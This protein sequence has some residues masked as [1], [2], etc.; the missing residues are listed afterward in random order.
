MLWLSM[1]VSGFPSGSAIPSC[2]ERGRC[3]FES[4]APC[5]DDVG[6][7]D[8]RVAV[9]MMISAVKVLIGITA[10]LIFKIIISSVAIATTTMSSTIT[11]TPLP[12]P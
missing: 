6:D 3:G 12:R 5:D 8:D 4:E 2:E 9:P 1:F 11:A 7:D 10:A